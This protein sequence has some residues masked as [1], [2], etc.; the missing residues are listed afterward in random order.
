M[1]EGADVTFLPGQLYRRRELH[2]QFGGQQQGG[3]STP[4][5]VPFIFLITGESGKQHGYADEWYGKSCPRCGEKIQR[6]RYAENETNY[7]AR[8]QTGG[9]MLADRALSRLL[10]ADWP[11]TLEELEQR[12]SKR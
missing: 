8:C 4:A 3:I 1:N 12:R 5:K 10:K 6:I 7:C 2:K 11:R 9:R